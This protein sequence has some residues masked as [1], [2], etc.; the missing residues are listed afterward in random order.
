M[1]AYDDTTGEELDPKEVM[2]ARA[3]EV[4]YIH[5]KKVWAKIS[6]QEAEAQGWRV[7]KARWIDINKGDKERPKYRSRSVAKEFNDGEV[8]GLFASTPPLEALRYMISD[9]ATRPMG[10]GSGAQGDHD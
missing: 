6:R 4:G 3:K 8:D 9:A 10:Q 1:Y 7:L 2:R 5:E